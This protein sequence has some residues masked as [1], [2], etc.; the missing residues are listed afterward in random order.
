[1]CAGGL[2]KNG[3]GLFCCLKPVHKA[4]QRKRMY[5]SANE[6]PAAHI[7]VCHNLTGVVF[8]VLYLIGVNRGFHA[9]EAGKVI[10]AGELK[11]IILLVNLRKLLGNDDV[12]F[13]DRLGRNLPAEIFKIGKSF[14]VA[15]CAGSFP[16]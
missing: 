1:M 6:L 2:N 14:A 5:V 11:L 8:V 10:A 9:A 15:A 7:K 3:S 12:F 16:R 13:T 4:V